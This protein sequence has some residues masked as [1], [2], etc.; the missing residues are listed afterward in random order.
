M[1]IGILTFHWAAN[2]GAVL[3]TYASYYYFKNILKFEEVK[4]ID[5]QNINWF[6]KVTSFLMAKF[7]KKKYEKS[8]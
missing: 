1:K 5:M 8:F 2:H 7:M 4:V 3:Q 6:K